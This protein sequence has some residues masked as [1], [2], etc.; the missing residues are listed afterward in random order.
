MTRRAKNKVDW[1]K[2]KANRDYF[3][4]TWR[5]DKNLANS[6]A[7]NGSA[8]QMG[9]PNSIILDAAVRQRLVRELPHLSLVNVIKPESVILLGFI[10][11]ILGETSQN[12]IANTLPR[13]FTRGRHVLNCWLQMKVQSSEP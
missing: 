10:A 11:E 5:R 9:G 12:S 2:R 3:Q 1:S 8:G 6:E 4:G 7:K 13:L